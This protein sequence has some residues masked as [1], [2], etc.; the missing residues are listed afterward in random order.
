MTVS[1]TG[2]TLFREI[3]LMENT[4]GELYNNIPEYSNILNILEYQTAEEKTERH[5]FNQYIIDGINQLDPDFFDRF[6]KTI[7]SNDPYLITSEIR[8]GAK[9]LTT[10]ALIDEKYGNSI[11]K[12]QEAL[13]GEN[14]DL[15]N[16]ESIDNFLSKI[17]ST[18]NESNSRVNKEACIAVVGVLALAVAAAAAIVYTLF[19]VIS[20]QSMSAMRFNT[21]ELNLMNDKIVLSIIN[22]Y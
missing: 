5:K 20:E 19:W 7:D 16:P 6:K 14:V 12:L 15:S 8:M 17:E 18:V 1:K 2:E 10:V 22:N 13:K 4:D 3:L 9:L 21:N 11:E